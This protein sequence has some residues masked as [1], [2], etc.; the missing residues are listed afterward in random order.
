MSQP[1]NEFRQ[2]L[3]A[4]HINWQPSFDNYVIGPH[5]DTVRALQ[6]IAQTSTQTRVRVPEAL[7]LWGGEGT[8]KTHLLLAVGQLLERHSRG[9]YIDLSLF[10][11][12]A[13]EVLAPGADVRWLLLDNIERISNHIELEKALMRCIDQS[14]VAPRTLLLSG[15]DQPDKLGLGLPDLVS[16]L[17]QLPRYGLGPLS[18]ADYRLMLERRSQVAGLSLPE[19]L[20][21]YL[22]RYL[23][24]NAGALMRAYEQ[25]ETAALE[26]ARSITVPFASKILGRNP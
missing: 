19:A 12:Q 11:D 1:L 15:C 13:G 3:L 6:V 24:K 5:Q 16:R 20:P 14:L 9:L 23:P 18:D 21:D 4:F 25:I 26:Q 17:N 7:Y 22:L 8:G 10:D 2:S